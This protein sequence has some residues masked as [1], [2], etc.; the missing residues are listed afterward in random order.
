[1][2]PFL[3]RNCHKNKGR[4]KGREELD[5]WM[6]SIGMANWCTSC[7]RRGLRPDRVVKLHLRWLQ[8][9]AE[10]AQFARQARMRGARVSGPRFTSEDVFVRDKWV[11]HLCQA[12]VD[13]LLSGQDPW[14]PTIDHIVPI[15]RGGLHSLE[16]CQLAH[17]VCNSRKGTKY[18]PGPERT[19][20]PVE[21]ALERR[22]GTFENVWQMFV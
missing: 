6:K 4:L 1:M 11:C 15:A 18:P 13:D 2:K 20:A 3:C 7:V 17:R 14:G 21:P 22:E 8:D 5:P 16:N 9:S 10:R 19:S 12:P